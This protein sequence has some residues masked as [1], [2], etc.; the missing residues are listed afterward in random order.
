MRQTLE[1]YWERGEKMR[2]KIPNDVVEIMDWLKEHCDINEKT[3]KYEPKKDATKEEIEEFE[4]QMSLF[5]KRS[6]EIE[7]EMK[8]IY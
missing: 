5:N 4:K 6:K 2:F 3:G 7:K 8:D 1:K